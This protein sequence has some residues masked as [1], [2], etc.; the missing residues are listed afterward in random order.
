MHYSPPDSS[1]H[2]ISQRRLPGYSPWNFSGKNTGAGCQFLLQGS[3]PPRDWTCIRH[4]QAGCL[5]LS[6]LRS[7]SP[8]KD[9]VCSSRRACV[10]VLFLAVPRMWPKEAIKPSLTHLWHGNPA[11]LAYCIGSLKGLK[12]IMCVCMKHFINLKVLPCTIP[13]VLPKPR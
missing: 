5:P 12:E 6:H 13:T 9:C 7:C 3:S 4:W 10:Q 1:V 2:G 8:L 11:S